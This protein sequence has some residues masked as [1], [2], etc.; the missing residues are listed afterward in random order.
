MKQ[1][2]AFLLGTIIALGSVIASAATM[3]A[4]SCSAGGQAV[5][6]E[7]VFG[8]TDSVPPPKPTIIKDNYFEF[9]K[10]TGTILKYNGLVSTYIEIPNQIDGVPV[11]KIGPEAFARRGLVSV[12]LPNQLEEIGPKA[13]SWNYLDSITIPASVK[14]IDTN[15][16]RVAG[17]L[18]NLKFEEGNLKEIAPFAFCGCSGLVSIRLPNSLAQPD[19]AE[20]GQ[21]AFWTE[22]S[23]WYGTGKKVSIK[24]GTKLHNNQFEVFPINSQIIW[25]TNDNAPTNPDTINQP[26]QINQ[27]VFIDLINSITKINDYNKYD[28]EDMAFAINS[29]AKEAII[30]A[31]TDN[32]DGVFINPAYNLDTAVIDVEAKAKNQ[33]V[34]ISIK[35]VPTNEGKLVDFNITLK[36]FTKDAPIPE[37]YEYGTWKVGQRFEKNG[38][39]YEIIR[40]PKRSYWDN[41]PKYALKLVNADTSKV[42]LGQMADDKSGKVTYQDATKG[43]VVLDLLVIGQNSVNK[44]PICEGGLTTIGTGQKINLIIPDSV[45]K[46]EDGA[47]YNVTNE[48]EEFSLGAR[49]EI[50]GRS[51]F[52]GI[53][54]WGQLI[55]PDTITSLDK[56]C[57]SVTKFTGQVTLPPL[58]KNVPEYCFSSSYYIDDIKFN[59]GL[60]KI[61]GFSFYCMDIKKNLYIPDS[62]QLIGDYAFGSTYSPKISISVPQHTVVDV[63]RQQPTKYEIIRRS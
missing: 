45:Y 63:S 34:N 19:A 54:Y 4:V 31:L 58:L 62:V 42:D 21:S 46:I 10:S 44:N 14:K 5:N 55:F 11:K 13:F 47:F 1:R 20:I 7:P 39:T 27:G 3:V 23:N 8:Q 29:Y 6:N 56:G 28:A 18:T 53:N 50:I 60:E 33:A 2:K 52:Q 22:Q 32:T 59:N 48:I 17:T 36:G 40:N 35:R 38:F 16:F 49:L 24:K 61:E 41:Q 30:Q 15:A 43:N 9:D 26:T 25:R 12:V 51:V 37:G 57:F